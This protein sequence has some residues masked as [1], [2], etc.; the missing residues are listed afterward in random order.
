MSAMVRRFCNECHREAL[1]N[2]C[3]HKERINGRCTFCGNPPGGNHGT[4]K[5]D[6]Q[7]LIMRKQSAKPKEAK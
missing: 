4:G 5:R 2:P 6:Y 3:A 1:H 7:E